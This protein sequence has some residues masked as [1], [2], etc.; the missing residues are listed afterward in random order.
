MVGRVS[1]KSKYILEKNGRLYAKAIFSG[2][3]RSQRNQYENIALLKVEGAKNKE[4]AEFYI[5]KKCA[6]MYKCKNGSYNKAG[7]K[8]RVRVLWG[9]VTRTHG[10]TGTV[11]AK[12]TSNLPAHAMSKRVRLMLYPSRI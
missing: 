10:N 3:K 8:T 12:F 1:K 6:F 5:G 9:K 11:R 7:K 4:A 2:F